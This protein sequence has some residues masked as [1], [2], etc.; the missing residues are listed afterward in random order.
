MISGSKKIFLAP[1]LLMWAL[2]GAAGWLWAGTEDGI[3]VQD[4]TMLLFVGEDLEVL[5]I[6]SRREESAWQ[7]PAVAYVITREELEEKGVRT[8]SHALEMVPGFYMAR[9]EWGSRPYLRGIPDSVLLLYDTVPLLS[10]TTKSLHPLNNELSLAPVKRVEIVRGPGSVLWGPDAFAGLVNVVPM[11]GKDFH[12]VETGLLYGGPGD[13]K[14]FHVNMGCDGGYWDGFLSVSG[15]EGE[16]D[17]TLTDL[18]SFWGTGE[19]VVPPAE[20]FG[21]D[22]P[23]RSGYL[24]GSGRFSFR[25][26]FVLSG[27]LSDYER[28]YAMSGP[29]GTLTWPESRGGLNGFVKME[30]KKRL[31]RSSALRLTA[32]Y[33]CLKPEYEVVDLSLEPVEH[34]S[35]GEL[36]YDRSFLAGRSLFTAGI[37]SRKK[38]VKDVP[39]WDSYLPDYLGPENDSF[40]PGIIEEDYR[41]R[42]WSS[43]GQYTVKIG[44]VDIWAGLRN[45][46]HDAYKDHVSWN[47]GASW[48]PSS[49]WIV[50]SLYGTA[51]RT[52]FS[53][54]LLEE[55][56]PELEKI[57]TYTI[58]VAWKPSGKVGLSVCG[59]SSRIENHIM[60][61]PYAGLSLPNRQDIEGVEIEGCLS[62]ARDL[63]LSA[64]LTLMDNSGPDETYHFLDSIYV[65]PDG[66]IEEIYGDR[67]YPYDMGP[68]TLFNLTGTWRPHERITTFMRLGYSSSRWLIYPRGEGW[69]AFRS[70]SGAWLLNMSA[71]VRDLFSRGTELT[72]SIRNLT[73]RDYETPGT[74]NSIEGE[75][76]S[77]EVVLRKRW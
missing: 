16:E 22:G 4:D 51:Y 61:D 7:A 55:T 10:D 67:I 28:P 41:T 46:E 39:I 2:F 43:F 75:P 34:T 35:Y 27:R 44:D 53:S 32:Y 15:R 40:L 5:S 73:D 18:V 19:S 33:H 57:M 31:D 63:D 72:F 17:D 70:N 50:K 64:N 24:E 62:P 56:E 25:D 59:F 6:A 1:L 65:R 9:K 54:Q 37:S 13:Q 38:H 45:D 11:S 8:L 42:L 58:Q 3:A 14:G 48:S 36:L 49:R 76:F 12:G 68:D 74:Y 20:R 52:P 66:T 60:E 29:D 23:D 26:W 77:V 69:E 21:E 30:A 47:G 71:S